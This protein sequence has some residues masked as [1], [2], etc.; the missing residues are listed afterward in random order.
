MQRKYAFAAL[1]VVSVTLLF[2]APALGSVFV[3]NPV[4]SNI[5]QTQSF[6]QFTNRTSPLA[7]TSTLVNQQGTEAN[8]SISATWTRSN[9]TSY[10]NINGFIALALFKGQSADSYL[11]VS[12]HKGNMNISSP[13][14]YLNQSQSPGVLESYFT[15]S[16]WKDLRVPVQFGSSNQLNFSISFH[17][18][19]SE[20]KIL[21]FYHQSITLE[22]VAYTPGTGGVYLQEIVNLS[23]TEVVLG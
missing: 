9:D 18:N 11:F 5:N 6:A 14:L 10:Q 3:N 7:S 20:S 4:H 22:V 23:L 12:S 21:H 17:A 13:R 19:S 15:E 8:I 1:I 2:L 16:G